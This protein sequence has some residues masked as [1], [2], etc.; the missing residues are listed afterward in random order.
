MSRSARELPAWIDAGVIPLLNLIAAFFVTG[1]VILIIGESP[2]ESVEIMF[3]GAFGY[4]SL[5][6]LGAALRAKRTFPDKGFYEGLIYDAGIGGESF[7]SAQHSGSPNQPD[8]PR[9]MPDG[10][11]RYDIIGRAY[12]SDIIRLRDESFIESLIDYR[13]IPRIIRFNFDWTPY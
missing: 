7:S 4:E 12:E 3:N 5:R 8:R 6:H 9:I 10:S 1:I 13:L 11:S 2:V